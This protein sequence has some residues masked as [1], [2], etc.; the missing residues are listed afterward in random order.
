[1][2]TERLLTML[3]AH[4]NILTTFLDAEAKAAQDAELTVYIMAAFGRRAS[5]FMSA[6]TTG[7]TAMLS[8]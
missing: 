2:N 5:F 1:M 6:Q 8:S 3:R 4:L 7:M